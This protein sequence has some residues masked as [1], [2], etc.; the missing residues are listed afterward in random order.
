VHGC[1]HRGVHA[2]RGQAELA[3]SSDEVARF[4]EAAARVGPRRAPERYVPA[5]QRVGEPCGDPVVCRD[6]GVD[7]G[8][9]ARLEQGDDAQAPAEEL[10]RAVAGASRERDDLGRRVEP[11]GDVC[12]GR[13]GV[14][15]CRQRDREGAVVAEGACELD[16][17]VRERPSTFVGSDER[18]RHRQAREY[19]G[20]QGRVRWQR[21]RRGFERSKLPLVEHAHFEA[22]EPGGE[23]ER[24]PREQI[25]VT[26][27]APDVGG[28]G[29]GRR[30]AV[31]VAA[32]QAR[33]AERQPRLGPDTG[34]RRAV[35]REVE[36]LP[37]EPDR[38][39]PRETHECF[40]RGLGQDRRGSCVVG[41]EPTVDDVVHQR[42]G[43]GARRAVAHVD[44]A[45]V[46]LPTLARADC[47]FARFTDERM[48]ERPHAGAS[49]IARDE[50]GGLRFE[51]GVH[52]CVFVDAEH[53]GDRADVELAP[54]H[55]GS[56]EHGCAIRGQ[57]REPAREHF[58][59]TAGQDRR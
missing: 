19:Q 48:R 34:V 7:R 35:R 23:A 57:P 15:T 14:A 17:L 13:G 55:R 4:V 2:V 47:V 12:G 6:L 54:E 11:L 25:G 28:R 3:R 56:T 42:T 41:V 30:A 32:A 21:R 46:E 29:E 40:A 26:V 44:G 22:P 18:E 58:S 33:V 50:P 45:A 52:D 20:S 43:A 1:E 51:E 39:R 27:F 36:G 16:R 5:V 53:R 24:G 37:G 31:V 38:L 9:V 49:V 10:E 8:V 59:H